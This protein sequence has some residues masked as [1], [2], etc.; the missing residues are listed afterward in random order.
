MATLV[1][2][3]QDTRVT[4]ISRAGS[5]PHVSPVNR[6]QV[7]DLVK[8]RDVDVGHL[9]LDHL[10]VVDRLLDSETHLIWL[11]G[12]LSSRELGSLDHLLL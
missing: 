8:V 5:S 3:A 11:V 7:H 2:H 12:A 9:H 4:R 10:L 1:L 6:I